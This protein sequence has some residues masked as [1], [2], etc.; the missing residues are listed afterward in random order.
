[1]EELIKNIVMWR[2]A[3][4]KRNA[5]LGVM[6][7]FDSICVFLGEQQREIIKAQREYA[8]LMQSIEEMEATIYQ[9]QLQ[10]TLLLERLKKVQGKTWYPVHEENLR[11]AQE[12]ERLKSGVGEFV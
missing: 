10:E 9:Y 8:T 6:Q 2:T 7:V 4:E 5:N 3:L 12:I 1:V 11:L